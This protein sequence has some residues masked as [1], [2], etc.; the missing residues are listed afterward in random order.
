MKYDVLHS[1]RQ[2]LEQENFS[3]N[4]RKQYYNFTKKVLGALEWETA[5][6]IDPREVAAALAQLKTANDVSAA[7]NGL[8]LFCQY[9][10]EC[11]PLG[12]PTAKALK[13]RNR[14]KRK[15]E[16]LE[17]TKVRRQINSLPDEAERMAYRV[18][19]A[20]G[21]RVSEAANL[22][23]E[24]IKVIT[25]TS[26]GSDKQTLLFELQHTKKGCA[27]V[28]YAEDAYLLERLPDFIRDKPMG[29]PIFKACKTLKNK[30][31]SLNFECHDL[32]RAFAL[33]EYAKARQGLPQEEALEQVRQELR[34][35]SDRTTQRYLRR[36]IAK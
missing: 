36:K 34:H 35:E 5:A 32:R 3:E 14:A 15:W 21:M 28:A 22:C 16:P 26:D 19:L 9:F 24:D 33:V 29:E 10:P 1:F 17:L 25:V 11:E 4:T 12:L 2:Q 20:S 6:E 18:M 7:R 27:D 23:P 8:R 30:A 31:L 13:K